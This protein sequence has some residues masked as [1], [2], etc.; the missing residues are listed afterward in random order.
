MAPDRFRPFAG[1]G[2]ETDYPRWVPISA[3][4]LSSMLANVLAVVSTALLVRMLG[5]E[6]FGKAALFTSAAMTLG[7]VTSSGICLHIL[8]VTARVVSGEEV[9]V[10]IWIGTIMGQCIAALISVGL[11]TMGLLQDERSLFEY[12]LTAL[13]LHFTTSDALSKNRLVGGQRL[14]P[15]A[16]ATIFGSISTV[17][18]QLLGA[19][20]AGPRGY[21]IG[22]A[23][24]TGL[25]ALSSWLACQASLP[26]MG[27]W[28]IGIF[29]RMREREL[30]GFITLGTLAACVVPLAHWLNSLM[31]AHKM[32]S[33][34]EV[35]MLT[36]AMQFFNMVIF[37]PTILNKIVLPK[38]I[39]ADFNRDIDDSRSEAQ[40]QT[41]RMILLTAPMLLAVWALSDLITSIYRFRTPDGITVILCFVGG[42]VLACA[43]IPLSN[44]F[45]SHSKMK[46]G[47][48]GNL[49]WA[50]IYLGLAWAIPGGAISTAISLFC[51]YFLNLIIAL[52]LVKASHHAQ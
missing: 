16:G 47:L 29:R 8:R 5:G 6:A 14:M 30:L 37:V 13:S 52:F 50:A 51:A 22:F 44:Y 21:M 12:F 2:V 49:L 27:S 9:R 15:L 36:I 7:T 1:E 24:G 35:A 41:W 46:L 23:M 33:Y 11:L 34:G 4:L 20:V 25:N 32:N 18:L 10:Q 28:P 43:A 48:V 38:T 3:T 17:G 42:S 39:K 26:K 45:V 40:R 19:Y 31:A